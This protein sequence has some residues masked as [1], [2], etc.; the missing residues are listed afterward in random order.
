METE[1]RPCFTK[2]CQP[3]GKMRNGFVTG[4]EADVVLEGC[5]VDYARFFQ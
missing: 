4:I 1:S 5:E 2:L 3:V